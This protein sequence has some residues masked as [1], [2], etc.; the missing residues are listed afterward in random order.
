[1]NK[2]SARSKVSKQPASTAPKSGTT[3][4]DRRVLE[5][6]TREDAEGAVAAL[7]SVKAPA[8]VLREAKAEIAEANKVPIPAMPT[9]RHPASDAAARAGKARQALGDLAV[10]MTLNEIAGIIGVNVRATDFAS[11]ALDDLATQLDG[12]SIVAEADTGGCYDSWCVVENIVARMK[13][14]SRVTAWLEHESALA[15]LPEVSP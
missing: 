4:T 15:S 7:R 12:V 8:E 9:G 11:T 13:L 5:Q 2:V 6:A 1:M 3:A 10:P 14:A